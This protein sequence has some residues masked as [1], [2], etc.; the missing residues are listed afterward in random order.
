MDGIQRSRINL[1]TSKDAV[2]KGSRLARRLASSLHDAAC[3]RD[4]LHAGQAVRNK[5]RAS[6]LRRQIGGQDAAALVDETLHG[7]A[8]CVGARGV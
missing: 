8:V 3:A 1:R 2:V 6:T 4:A 5:F 7:L